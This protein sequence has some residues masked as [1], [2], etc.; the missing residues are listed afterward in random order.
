MN[1]FPAEKGTTVFSA[2]L[3]WSE[4]PFVLRK[5]L[6]PLRPRGGGCA[7]TSGK[8]ASMLSMLSNLSGISI[9]K[10]I[11][12]YQNAKLGG[13]LMFNASK[14]RI[15]SLNIQEPKIGYAYKVDKWVRRVVRSGEY[16]IRM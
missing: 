9:Q 7:S 4:G 3:V 11:S 6:P 8:T 1:R 13:V 15:E 14:L 16:A 12:T 2:A 5:G 10:Y